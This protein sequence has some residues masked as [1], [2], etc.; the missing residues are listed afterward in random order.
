MMKIYEN[1]KVFD[2]YWEYRIRKII[3]IIYF[4]D[5]N[6]HISFQIIY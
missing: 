6:A 1:Y 5:Y 4:T 2:L 3:R